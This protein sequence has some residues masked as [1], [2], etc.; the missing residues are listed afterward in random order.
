[1]KITACVL[2]AAV[3]WGVPAHAQLTRQANTTLSLPAELPVATGY[4]TSSAI[5]FSNGTPM[6]F[7]NPMCVT[8]EGLVLTNG[9]TGVFYA[10]C[11]SKKTQSVE[12]ER[13]GYFY[14]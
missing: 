14:I 5:T 4:A 2:I 8:S 1:M 12:G 10:L 13:V 11:F 7:L 9:Q 3:L 6:T